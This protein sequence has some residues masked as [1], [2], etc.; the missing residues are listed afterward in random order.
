MS[1]DSLYVVP[2]FWDADA[3]EYHNKGFEGWMIFGILGFFNFLYYSDMFVNKYVMTAS[4]NDGATTPYDSQ[5]YGGVGSGF[6]SQL[7][8][9]SAFGIGQW[10]RV[11]LNWVGWFFVM[12]CWTGTLIPGFYSPDVWLF[13]FG[14]YFMGTLHLI[15][16]AFLIIVW[17]LS[18]AIY[19]D[20][21]N[22]YH[23]Y[24]Y[25]SLQDAW[26]HRQANQYADV[27]G[28]ASFATEKTWIDY[29]L[30][31]AT[32][33]GLFVGIPLLAP[34]YH[35]AKEKENEQRIA[36]RN[37]Y[38]NNE[39]KW[40]TST[41]QKIAIEKAILKTSEENAEKAAAEDGKSAIEIEE[42]NAEEAKEW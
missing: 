4:F 22:F 2:R 39:R 32:C 10:V 11:F 28:H 7:G 1:S 18:I 5:L 34:R 27:T 13:N 14:A 42:E 26:G 36:I 35:A 41:L 3:V 33:V 25:F 6:F 31:L 9:K 21:D 8:F 38:L 29:E 37:T 15:R 23:V 24:D 19:N 17:L 12:M 40:K 20:Y 30:E 16:T